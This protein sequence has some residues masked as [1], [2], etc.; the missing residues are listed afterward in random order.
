MGRNGPSRFVIIAKIIIWSPWI[1]PLDTFADAKARKD[2]VAGSR[3]RRG[4]RIGPDPGAA[5]RPP[6]A[7]AWSRFRDGPASGHRSA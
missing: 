6:T 3:G 4:A 7:G 5:S 2:V 1:I